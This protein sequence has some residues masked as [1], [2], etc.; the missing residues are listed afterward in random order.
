[1]SVRLVKVPDGAPP[2][3]CET[4][5]AAC[6]AVR[7]VAGGAREAGG[8]PPSF[9]A[10][11]SFA[12]PRS[13]AASGSFAA[14]RSF[15]DAGS[16]LGGTA[17]GAADP[18]GVLP[19]QFAQVIVEIMAGLRPPKQLIGLTTER[20]RAQVQRLAPLLASDRRPKIARI[21]TSRPTARVVEMTVI[22]RVGPR[23]RA[24]AVRLEHLAARPATP[25]RPARPDRWLCTAIEAG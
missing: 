20:A 14:S 11:G 13:F 16:V 15:A 17:P 10:P 9:A 5:G 23:L 12:A 21:V 3:D 18:S 22:V 6:P 8:G 4:H 1:M 2:Y 7:A 19:G 25:G 24:L